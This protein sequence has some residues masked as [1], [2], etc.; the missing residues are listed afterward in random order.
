[1]DVI[2]HDD[3]MT[4]VIKGPPEAFMTMPE[5]SSRDCGQRQPGKEQPGESGQARPVGERR[6]EFTPPDDCNDGPQSKCEDAFDGR[7][8]TLPEQYGSPDDQ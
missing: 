2:V 8:T 3:G 1:M 7:K 5:G 4:M 6:T